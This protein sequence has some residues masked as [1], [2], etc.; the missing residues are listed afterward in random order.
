[1]KKA[2]LPLFI[3]LL[4]SGFLFAQV[5]EDD[6]LIVPKTSIPPVIDGEL[7][8]LV[9]NYI[10][11]TLAIKIDNADAAEPDDWFDLFGTFRLMWDDENLYFW[12]EVQDD[13]INSE[14]GD[15]QY[16]G[17]ELYFDADN[18]KT[19]EAYDGIDD[20]QMRF[21]VG[22]STVEEVDTGYGTG[23]NWGFSTA[24]INYV[25]LESDFGWQ[26]EAAIPIADL[27]LEPDL[28]FG[29][30][31]QIND[32]DAA[33]REN[34]YRW[35]AED[36]N[37]WQHANLFGTAMMVSN[38]V[39]KEV[40]EI[41]K[42]SAPTIDG[43][44]AAGEWA[45]AICL[46]GTR[47]EKGEIPNLYDHVEG[48]EDCRDWGWV[49][50][51]DQNFYYYLKVWDDWYDIAPDEANNWEFDSVELYF[52]GDNSDTAPYDGIDDIQIRFNLG[53]TTTESIDAG[54]GT[55]ASWEWNKDGVSYVVAETDLGWDVEAAIPL[56]D[57]QLEAGLDFG[58]DWQ[59]NDCDN[60]DVTPN[61]TVYRWWAP[62]EPEWDN[63]SLFGTVILVPAFTA[64]EQK[65]SVTR[66]D[67]YELTQNYPNPF[68]PTTTIDFSLPK[69]SNVRLTVF[70]TL[71]EE[72]ATLVNE[73]K[74]AGWYTVD[75]DGADLTSGIYFYKM[76]TGNQTLTKKM[77]LI[78]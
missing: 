74:E 22:E 77:M 69:R 27:M 48:W 19:L 28:E 73:V 18:S 62:S 61:R 72:V 58:F 24:G 7:D 53:Q 49:K 12:L 64:V 15:W 38:R 39:L 44:M 63:A 52:D 46:S 14:G 9:W 31:V 50:W 40:L 41:P 4:F 32:A 65:P 54:Y 30:D 71:G 75:F 70:N 59:M 36:N 16:D 29:F 55:A 45:D 26:V 6:V 47:L 11:E 17:V 1:M 56:A 21:N 8:T 51:D 3:V 42:G 13:M 20:L 67:A 68:N 25:V 60:P 23:A 35:W 78:K 57:M 33:T 5:N 2:F 10:G 76:R 43:V 37:E 66:V 34:M